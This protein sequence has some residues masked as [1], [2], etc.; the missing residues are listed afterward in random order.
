MLFGVSERFLTL[1]TSVTNT[2]PF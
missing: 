1:V 2:H